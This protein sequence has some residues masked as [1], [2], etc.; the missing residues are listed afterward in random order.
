MQRPGLSFPSGGPILPTIAPRKRLSSAGRAWVVRSLSSDFQLLHAGSES[1]HRSNGGCQFP[2]CCRRSQHVTASIISAYPEAG[3]HSG[4]QLFQRTTRQ[5]TPTAIGRE[6]EPLARPL[7]DEFDAS[8]FSFSVS[9]PPELRPGIHQ[10]QE[11]ANTS[12]RERRMDGS[13]AMTSAMTATS[14]NPAESGE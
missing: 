12:S 2:A 1:L 3:R 6:L 4:G 9:R 7:I 14:S 11:S 13:T 5:V 10:D 8:L